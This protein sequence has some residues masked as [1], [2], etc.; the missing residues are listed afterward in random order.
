[1]KLETA[2]YQAIKNCVF[3]KH[4]LDSCTDQ[5]VALRACHDLLYSLQKAGRKPGETKSAQSPTSQLH[6]FLVT[7]PN[8][9]PSTTQ[10][11]IL[12]I[13]V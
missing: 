4:Y 7:W 9:S 5:N 12:K 6:L 8:D 1:M 13:K 3:K 2:L 10:D 11:S